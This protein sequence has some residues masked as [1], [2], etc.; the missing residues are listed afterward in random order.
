MEDASAEE[1]MASQQ[2]PSEISMDAPLTLTVY[3]GRGES[4]VG[5]LLDQ[6]ETDTGVD[7]RVRYGGTAEL[8]VAILEEGDRSP[9]DVFFAQDA[10]ALGALQDAGRFTV[11]DDE[12]LTGST[13]SSDRPRAVGWACPAARASSCTPP[14]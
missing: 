2:M 4:L 14:S 9:A 12:F 13:Q 3:S 5:P 6:F 1:E 10:G 8:A 11:L 7:V